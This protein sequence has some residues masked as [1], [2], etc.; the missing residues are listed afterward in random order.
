MAE[1]KDIERPI[2]TTLLPSITLKSSPP[3]MG[4]QIV[5]AL[6]EGAAYA[7]DAATGKVLWRRFVGY[8]T[9]VPPTRVG[10]Q[11]GGSF[12]FLSNAM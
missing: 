6:A 1:T 3:G 2:K 5:C 11:S 4:G 7:L 12:I 10:P 8:D 9:L